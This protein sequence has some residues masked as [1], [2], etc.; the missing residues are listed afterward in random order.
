MKA[1]LF[2]TVTLLSFLAMASDY[3]TVIKTSYIDSEGQLH[4]T[5]DY[6]ED[7]VFD[8]QKRAFCFASDVYDACRAL[9]N[10]IQRIREDFADGAEENILLL[11]CE[12]K[13][14][15]IKA[16]YIFLSAKAK[17][18]LEKNTT[19]PPCSGI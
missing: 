9:A 18:P 1:V 8:N 15:T 12:V 6:F 13:G 4:K 11:R 3:N 2:A 10:D 16:K 17:K 19:I 7:S 14:Q 5:L